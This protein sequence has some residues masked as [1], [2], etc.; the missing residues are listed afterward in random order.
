MKE[1][2]QVHEKPFCGF[3]S[4]RTCKS[5]ILSASGSVNGLSTGFQG[6]LQRQSNEEAQIRMK[7]IKKIRDL[8]FPD[9]GF[10]GFII[11]SP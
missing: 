2:Q 7:N 9:F 3:V 6:V 8:V 10:F 5:K 4:N 1:I 11:F